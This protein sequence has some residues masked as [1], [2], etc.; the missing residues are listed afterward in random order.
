VTH[1]IARALSDEWVGIPVPE[2]IE[3]DLFAHVQAQFQENRERARSCRRGA[4]YLL[5]GLAVCKQC[6]YAHYGKPITRSN[7]QGHQRHYAYYRCTGND[8]SHFG[9]ERVCTNRPIRMDCLDQAVWQ[10]V[11][12][13]MKNP[14]RLAQQYARR[15]Q[16]LA[17]PSDGLR[18]LNLDKQLYQCPMSS[19]DGTLNRY[20]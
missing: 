9:G 15:L 16:S 17:Q 6:G 11:R 1:T 14:Q 13:L 10:E 2:L 20:L 18:R 12:S 5:Q 3:V 7:A 8:A 4:R 19:G